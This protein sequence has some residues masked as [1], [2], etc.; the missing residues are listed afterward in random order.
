MP[1]LPEAVRRLRG[2]TPDAAKVVE[3]GLARDLEH[4]DQA[5]LDARR[6]RHDPDPE[7]FRS[8]LAHWAARGPEAL[9]VLL[10]TSC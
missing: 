6:P 10:L 7:R 5:R 8:L 1:V 4:G 2:G 9:L 3:F